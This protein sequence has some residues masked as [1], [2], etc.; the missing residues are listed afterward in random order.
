MKDLLIKDEDLYGRYLAQDIVNLESGEIYGEAGEEIEEKLL[1]TLKELGLKEIP[2]LDI[3]HVN[4][5]AF[6]RTTLAIDKNSN[7]DEALLDI[8]RVMR[9]GEPPTPAAAQASVTRV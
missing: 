4:V 9:P 7:T 5:G 1:E 2:I 6:I 3:D 8:S